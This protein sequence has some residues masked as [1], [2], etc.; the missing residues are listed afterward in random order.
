MKVKFYN[1]SDDPLT[2]NKTLLDEIEKDCKPYEGC[3]LL[4]PSVILAYDETVANRNYAY[5]EEWGRY[6]FVGNPQVA[7]GSRIIIPMDVDPLMSWADGIRSAPIIAERSAN[8]YNSYIADPNINIKAY[9]QPEYHEIGSFKGTQLYLL[10][11][12]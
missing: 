10:G 5:I 3:T 11:V 9:A 2:L 6:Y 1:T 12:G 8:K 4:H 7:P